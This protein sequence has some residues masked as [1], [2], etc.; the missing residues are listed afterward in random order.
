MRRNQTEAIENATMFD[1]GPVKKLVIIEVYRS[2]LDVIKSLFMRCNTRCWRMRLFLRLKARKKATP[3]ATKMRLKQAR[4]NSTS[5]CLEYS[6][7]IHIS[8]RTGPVKLCQKQGI[9]QISLNFVSCIQLKKKYRSISDENYFL[10]FSLKY[11]WET[12]DLFLKILKNSVYIQP[13]LAGKHSP[14]W[15]LKT[16]H[17][18]FWRRLHQTSFIEL[19]WMKREGLGLKIDERGIGKR[20]Q[21]YYQ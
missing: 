20:Y 16:E 9:L 14:C 17:N 5:H 8:F 6:I 2:I 12:Q 11:F 7:G 19:R 21:L 15:N 1:L 3:S 4:H 10:S 13:P 18:K